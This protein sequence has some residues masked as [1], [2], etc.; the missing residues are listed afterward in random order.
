M[1]MGGFFYL[2]SILFKQSTPRITIY[3]YLELQKFEMI[4]YRT[5]YSK[6]S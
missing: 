1:K 3:F 5:L 2:N 4:F 6:K